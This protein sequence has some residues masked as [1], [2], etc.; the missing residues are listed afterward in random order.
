LPLPYRLEETSI[1]P[2]GFGLGKLCSRQPWG[3]TSFVFGSLRIFFEDSAS[4]DIE[5][6]SV[7]LPS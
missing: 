3:K 6:A 4:G 5:L 1:S 2:L 7:F